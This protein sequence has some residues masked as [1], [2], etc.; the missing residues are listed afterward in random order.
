METKLMMG[1]E[2]KV[3][4]TIRTMPKE[5]LPATKSKGDF[6][7]YLVILVVVVLIL[8]IIALG[9]LFF[10]NVNKTPQ[11]PEQNVINQVQEQPVLEEDPIQETPATVVEPE[12]EPEEEIIISDRAEIPAINLV[13]SIPAQDNDQD[14]LSDLEE[15][16][17]ITSNAVPDTDED[18]YLDGTEVGGLYD[19]ATPGQL[20]EASPQVKIARNT[21]RNYQFLIPT[22]WTATQ[23]TPRGDEMMV[24][25]DNTDDLF[26][27]NVYDNPDRLQVTEWYREQVDIPDLAGFKNFSNPAGWTG[28]QSRD[29]LVVIATFGDTGP[30]ARAF[31]YVMEYRLGEE[32]TI[33]YPAI[34]TMILNSIDILE[35]VTNET[36]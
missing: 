35:P 30:G 17:F 21:G 7:K 16:I 11:V 19:P 15:A 27:I 29:N 28:I 32:S 34:W 33:N 24:R 4:G 3:E 13:S 18:S 20:L 8:V 31:I 36:E 23:N 12:E 22:K 6:G 5:Y 26:V 14:G 9:V 1:N 10:S 2:P 25:P